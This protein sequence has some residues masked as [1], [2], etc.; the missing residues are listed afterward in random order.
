MPSDLLTHIQHT[1]PYRDGK[2]IQNLPELDLDN[3]DILNDWGDQVALTSIDDVTASPDWIFGAAPDENGQIHNST[4]C[5]VIIVD[6]KQDTD[7]FYF[8][9]YSYDEGANVTQVLKPL[10]SLVKGPVAESGMHFG[11]H[12]GDW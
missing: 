12:V 8:Y 2:R 1:T 4:A 6:R 3:L 10:D 7:V 11:N 5:V 9:F